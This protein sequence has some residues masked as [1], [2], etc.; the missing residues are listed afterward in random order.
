MTTRAPFPS[1]SVLL[2][3]ASIGLAAWCL[4][5]QVHAQVVEPAT[6]A[7]APV[8][9]AGAKDTASPGK[10]GQGGARGTPPRREAVSRG[11]VQARHYP[12]SPLPPV[13]APPSKR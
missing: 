11:P 9:A 5:G 2:I 12:S 3:Q 7:G 1:R 8:P 6:D 13:P 10:A 4:A